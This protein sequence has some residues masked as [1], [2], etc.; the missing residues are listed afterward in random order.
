MK[1][2]V[3]FEK[4][5]ELYQNLDPTE[6]TQQRLKKKLSSDGKN[7]NSQPQNSDF[8]Q[9]PLCKL[10]EKR[11]KNKPVLIPN[12]ISTRTRCGNPFMDR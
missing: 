7:S 5:F 4:N 11:A 12:V 3:L 2:L 1:K 9:H 6:K 10:P 8:R